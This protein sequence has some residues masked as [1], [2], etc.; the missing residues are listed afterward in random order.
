MANL[1]RLIQ[2]SELKTTRLTNAAESGKRQR[3][4]DFRY[5]DECDTL[6]ILVLQPL[7]GTIVHYVDDHIGLLYEEE[8]LEVVGLRIEAFEKAFLPLHSGVQ[9]V[10]NSAITLPDVGQLVV[11][12]E[13]IRPAVVRELVKETQEALG[14]PGE[15]L[16]VL[17]GT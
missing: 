7:E 4:F 12:F 16:A 14:Y 15:R 2:T 13:R 6:L 10:W 11:S 17:V 5:D 1:E 8:S 9:R 3:I